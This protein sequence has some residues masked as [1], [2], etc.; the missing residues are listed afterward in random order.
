M[1]GLQD[2]NRNKPKN[3]KLRERF[4]K[5]WFPP[6][7]VM[8]AFSSFLSAAFRPQSAKRAASPSA[9]PLVQI[10][11]KPSSPAQHRLELEYSE[12]LVL[13]GPASMRRFR[14]SLSGIAIGPGDRIFVLGDGE[15]TIFEP[16]GD[17]IQSWKTPENASCLAVGPDGRV[18]IG[19]LG[20]MEIYREA[21]IRIGGFSAGESGRPA[22][23]TA[24]KVCGKGILVAD[25]A[26]RFIRL[27]DAGGKQV[28]EIGTQN[29]TRSFMLPNRCLDMDVDAKG[30]VYATDTGRHQVTSWLLDGS[31]LGH[32]G[33][34]GLQNPE[35]FVGC[36]N[37]VNLA[38]TPDGKVVTAEKVIARVKIYSVSG[39]L[40]ALIGP[41]HFDPGCT[42][43]HLAVDSKGRIL[44]ADPV[45]REI[46]IFSPAART[47]GSERI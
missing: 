41:E 1:G 23:V 46:K 20:R 33:K 6:A 18:Y 37:P 36:C 7:A 5:S 22:D 15:V 26:A 42:H 30:V 43:L 21:G 13:G 27:Y 9:T 32:F 40:I 38:A 11:F 47:G 39:K 28:C 44:V 34:F 16:N 17:V 3:E 10:D 19:L 14:R 35:D 24:I 31:P 8:G 25:A 29:K 2:S 4:L 12:S 45:R